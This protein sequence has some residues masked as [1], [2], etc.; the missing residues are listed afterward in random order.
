LHDSRIQEVRDADALLADPYIQSADAVLFHFAIRYPAFDAIHKISRLSRVMVYYHGVTPP[1][2]CR[3]DDRAIT[4]ESYRQA[5]GMVA[6]DQVL[7][8]S[9][10]LV[11]EV[12]GYGVPRERIRRVPPAVAVNPVPRKQ[13]DQSFRVLYVGRFV[14]AKGVLH[15]LEA[16]AR[17]APDHADMVLTLAGSRTFSDQKYLAELQSRAS[18]P[19][20]AGRVTFA[21]DEPSQRLAELYAS[22]DLFVL[23]SYHEGFGVPIIEALAAECQVIVT[24]AGAAPET[25]AGHG[26]VVPVGDESA[27]SNAML[28]SR[29]AW[30]SGRSVTDRGALPRETFQQMASDYAQSFSRDA[31]EDRFRAAVL[32]NCRS[33]M[34]ERPGL[35]MIGSGVHAK[36]MNLL[37]A[38]GLVA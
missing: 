36:H 12:L 31:F 28:R 10:H 25:L 23:P 27:L 21:F 35:G 5:H 9:E 19:R 18:D 17:L 33:V 20:L 15:L 1:S 3:G 7:V 29:E 26:Q 32:A 38:Q 16:F 4:T 22:A 30:A 13:A 8:T 24:R 14:P 2:V 6:A 11:P 37:R 34:G